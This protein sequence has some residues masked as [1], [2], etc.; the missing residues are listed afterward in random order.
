MTKR[1]IKEN[2]YS[3][4][5]ERNRVVNI[6]ALKDFVAEK[7]PS[8]TPLREVLLMEKDEIEVHDFLAKL[9]IWLKLLK[10]N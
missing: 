9:E 3:G 7:L 2:N 8:G 6:R 1:L 5:R 10:V 4:K